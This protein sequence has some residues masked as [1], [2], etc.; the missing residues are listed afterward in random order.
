M[1][2]FLIA[3]LSLLSGLI[4]AASAGGDALAL[5]RVALIVG[6]AKY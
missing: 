4:L 1:R 6:N 5:R 3:A 2:R